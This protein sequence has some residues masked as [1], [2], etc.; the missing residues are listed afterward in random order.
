M[1]PDRQRIDKW[2]FFARVAKSRTL[3]GKLALGGQ[4]RVNGNK[5]AQASH[6]VK[7]GDVLTIGLERR[8]IVYRVIACGTRRGPATEA[9]LLYEDISPP[10]LPKAESA[11]DQS[12]KRL[13]GAGRPT[14]K[15]RR[16]LESLIG[17]GAD[18]D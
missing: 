3:A 10:P 18:D 4:V 1:S 11:L 6:E 8:V 12:G 2:L 7:P 16:A 17:N 9:R 15:D 14:K 13:P 5:I